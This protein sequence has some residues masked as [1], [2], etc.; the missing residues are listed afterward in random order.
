M[1]DHKIVAQ[2]I[3]DRAKS[4][5]IVI[6]DMLSSCGI[7]V[8]TLSSL[9]HG[10]AIAYDSLAKIAQYLECSVDYLLG[11]DIPVPKATK[12]GVR[13]PV[14]GRVQAGVP[15]EAIEEVLDWEEIT[16][17]MASAGEFFA[18]KV[19]GRSMEPKLLEGDVLI[20]RMQPDVDDGDIAVVMVNGDDATV[21]KIKKSREG[22]MLL[23]FNPDFEPMFYS[24]REI[25]EKPVRVIGRVIEL[26]RPL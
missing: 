20:I 23:P 10:K 18:L 1:F 7:S 5:N 22:I 16:E 2:R 15:V 21:K 17:D 25:E 12:K 13:I 3:R 11:N 26:R 9:N 4:Q 24:N 19:R 8:N 6:K 14:L